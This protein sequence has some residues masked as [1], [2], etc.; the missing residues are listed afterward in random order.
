MS[1]TAGTLGV[2]LSLFTAP[3]QDDKSLK[4]AIDHFKEQYFKA[5][6]K[7][8]EKIDAVN[9]LSQTHHER[10]VKVLA[11]LMAEASLPVRIMIARSL[12]QFTDVEAAGKIGRASCRERV[13]TGV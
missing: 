10:I 11:P 5:G 4:P 6:A 2:V 12:G 3:P 13:L 8:D 7:D 9:Y 1:L